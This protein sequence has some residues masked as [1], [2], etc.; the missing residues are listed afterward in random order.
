VTPTR[1][2][3][4]AAN[5]DEAPRKGADAAAA[6]AAKINLRRCILLFPSLCGSLPS[7]DPIHFKEKCIELLS[8]EIKNLNNACGITPHSEHFSAP[9]DFF[10]MSKRK[11]PV[12]I[13]EKPAAS[14]S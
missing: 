7:G 10:R 4:S 11:L 6:A 13:H 2:V 1:T 9:N 3:F 12:S 5:A 8:R 14:D